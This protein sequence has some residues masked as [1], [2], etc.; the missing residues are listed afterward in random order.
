MNWNGEL[1]SC[2]N[3]ERD[4]ICQYKY[5]SRELF[6]NLAVVTFSQCQG[7]RGLLKV[8]K[9]PYFCSVSCYL[10]IWPCG[11]Q[12][13]NAIYG[14]KMQ[15]SICCYMQ[16]KRVTSQGIISFQRRTQTDSIMSKWEEYSRCTWAPFWISLGS[17]L[18]VNLA[19]KVKGVYL[20]YPLLGNV[21][22]L[23]VFF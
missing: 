4:D 10:R 9:S 17:I 21:D 18:H 20:D 2:L 22:F 12:G 7:Q 16:C 1:S 14:D 3:T 5:P 15:L 11:Y 6:E 19:L 23:K 8:W 13:H